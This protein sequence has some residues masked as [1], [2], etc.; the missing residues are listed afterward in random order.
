MTDS[1]SAAETLLISS[2]CLQLWCELVSVYYIT[3]MTCDLD[4]LLFFSPT[5]PK[6]I[7]TVNI[8]QV[9]KNLYLKFEGVIQY[10]LQNCIFTHNKANIELKWDLFSNT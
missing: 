10:P 6:E 2:F 3:Y 5:G 1:F 8:L 4:F 9:T 7:N